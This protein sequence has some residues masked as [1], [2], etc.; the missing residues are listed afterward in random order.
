ME[1]EKFDPRQSLQLID[2]MIN[3]AKN[4]FSENGHLYLVWG[5][6]VLF[7]SLLHYAAIKWA[8]WARPEWV[9]GLTWA[10]LLYQFFYISKRK[11]KARVRMYADEI[12]GAVWL[13]FVGCGGILG[14]VV[15]RLGNWQVMYS[16]ILMLYGIPTILSGAVLRF[17]PL[18]AGGL[19][20]WGLSIISSFLAFEYSILMISIAVIAAWIIPGY[21]MQVRHSEQQS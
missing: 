1:E 14:I 21:L 2:S 6:V 16:L 7:C 18:V 3:L 12:L 10:A 15:G 11:R 8:W 19:V 20:C 17:R 5:W 4:R 13:V 9:W